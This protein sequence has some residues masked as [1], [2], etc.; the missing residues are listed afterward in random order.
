MPH[1]KKLDT[2]ASSLPTQAL[3]SGTSPLHGTHRLTYAASR[4]EARPE[5]FSAPLPPRKFAF[6]DKEICAHSKNLTHLH[7]VCRLKLS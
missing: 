7:Q 2:F 3:P 6:E 5:A 1:S 4:P